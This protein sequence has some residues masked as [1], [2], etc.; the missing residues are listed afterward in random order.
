MSLANV[1]EKWGLSNE[2]M[3]PSCMLIHK[4]SAFVTGEILFLI[5]F[6]P[7]SDLTIEQL[8]VIT[9]CN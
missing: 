1:W 2:K 9:F 7:V 6:T 4:S 5:T 3:S 8:V